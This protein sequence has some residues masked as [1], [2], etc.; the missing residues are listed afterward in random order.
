MTPAHDATDYEIG[1]RHGLP[2]PTVIDYDGR[3]ILPAWRIEPD[4]AL[5]AR[6]DVGRDALAKY[7][8]LDRFAARTAIVADLEAAGALVRVEPYES[9]VPVSSR[10]VWPQ[11]FPKRRFMRS[12][13]R[14]KRWNLR[15]RMPSNWV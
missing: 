1:Q 12:I 6:F 5:R 3:I 14:R 15:T 4:A 11:N 9:T 13:F 7:V 8:G 2:M 10:S